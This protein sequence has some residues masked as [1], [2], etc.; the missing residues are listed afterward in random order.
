MPTGL[1]AAPHKAEYRAVEYPKH[2]ATPPGMAF[3]RGGAAALEAESPTDAVRSILASGNLSIG[4]VL[5]KTGKPADALVAY[6]NALEIRQ[7]LVDANPTNTA[8]Q[9]DL[10]IN[11]NNIG[12]LLKETGKP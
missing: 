6:K 7:K 5:S 3:V 4:M 10:A 8:F 2:S 11:H 1:R 12:V 9:S